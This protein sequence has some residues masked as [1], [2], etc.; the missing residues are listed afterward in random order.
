MNVDDWRGIAAKLSESSLRALHDAL[1]DVAKNDPA[2]WD[3]WQDFRQQADIIEAQLLERKVE[4][5]PIP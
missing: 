5:T 1:T 3:Q 4:F 2:E